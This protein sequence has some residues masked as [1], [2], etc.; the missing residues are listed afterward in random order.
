MTSL[1]VAVCSLVLV[2]RPVPAPWVDVLCHQVDQ[3]LS[4]LLV[5]AS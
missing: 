3:V 2:G 4:Q 1:Q 5:T